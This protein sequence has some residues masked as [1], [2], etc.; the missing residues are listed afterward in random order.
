MN[1]VQASPVFPSDPEDCQLAKVACPPHGV[2]GL[3]CPLSGLIHHSLSMV[4]VHSYNLFFSES[5]PRGT[6]PDLTT[7]L[8]FLMVKRLPAMWETWVQSLGWEDPLEMETATHSSTLAWKIPWTEDPDRLQSM[9]SHR[10][11]H[12][13]ATSLSF[14]LSIHYVCIFLTALDV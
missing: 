14:F 3:G 7:F 1:G 10:V 8:P 5:P 6:C 12:D 13:W 11:G 9:G 4:A 2:P